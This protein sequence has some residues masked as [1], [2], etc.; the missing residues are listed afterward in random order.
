MAV[1]YFYRF[2]RFLAVLAFGG[3]LVIVALVSCEEDEPELPVVSTLA[4][5]SIAHESAVAGGDVTH[6]GGGTISQR[7]VVWSQDTLPDMDSYLGKTNDGQGVGTY[8]STL[9]GLEPET[10]YHVRAYAVNR[11]GPA[12]GESR[13]FT[14]GLDPET[15]R[16]QGYVYYTYTEIPVQ[17]VEITWG[18]HSTSTDMEGF[19]MMD[20]LEK[21]T[22]LFS[23][24][25]DGYDSH[26]QELDLDYGINV[27]N[28]DMGSD[29]YTHRV[30]GNI[31]NVPWEEA[32]YY[33]AVALMNPDG[34]LSDIRA[35]SDQEGNYAMEN[36]PRGDMM[37]QFTRG[38]YEERHDLVHVADG[39]VQHDT[40]LYY[41]R[42]IVQV[43]EEFDDV[44]AAIAFGGGEVEYEGA[45]PVFARGLV[46]NTDAVP[47]FPM[48]NHTSDGGGGGAFDSFLTPLD[49]ETTNKVRAYAVNAHG[50]SYSEIIYLDTPRDKGRPCPDKASFTD[51]RDGR[52]YH[53]VQVGSQCWIVENMYYLPEV[54][55]PVDASTDEARHYVYGYDGEDLETALDQPAYEAY[56]ALYNWEAAQDA[57]PPGWRL[58]SVQDWGDL[59]RYIYRGYDE[60]PETWVA[61]PLKSCRQ[62]NSPL[63]GDCDTDAHPRWDAHDHVYGTGEFG[64]EAL[65]GGRLH[66]GAYFTHLGK[67]GYWW[68]SDG[69]GSFGSRRAMHRHHN[70]LV[71]SVYRKSHGY[72]VRCIRE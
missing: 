65:P 21:G 1:M 60:F 15:V 36:V 3:A 47:I 33:V 11:R 31:T 56:G 7:G 40:Q 46:W 38:D 62:Q 58:P 43:N 26:E 20:D 61:I 17:D 64:F 72:S 53:T 55:R 12:Y 28:F 2:F 16:L 71:G 30:Y 22:G 23:A 18:D 5:E 10:A 70:M 37:I 50:Q 35:F 66:D 29:Q 54:H 9:T 32:M 4:V 49:P 48:D 34:S 68:T 59:G 57:C 8:S 13:T 45:Q 14:T 69:T 24:V 51:P 63:G 52:E 42:P 6:D 25:K 67:G 41:K 39:D 27:H 44:Y 19:F